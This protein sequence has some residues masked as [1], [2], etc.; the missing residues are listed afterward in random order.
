MSECVVCQSV[1][2]VRVCCCESV[3]CRSMLYVSVL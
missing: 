2:Y 3:V 1:L